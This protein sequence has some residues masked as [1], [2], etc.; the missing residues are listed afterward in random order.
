MINTTDNAFLRCNLFTMQHTEDLIH[1]NDDEIPVM[2]LGGLMSYATI[3]CQV[4]FNWSQLLLFHQALSTINVVTFWRCWFA[5][6]TIQCCK[7]RHSFMTINFGCC[8]AYP[9]SNNYIPSPTAAT[10]VCKCTMVSL[11][12]N[13]PKTTTWLLHIAS[14]SRLV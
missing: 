13:K 6:L 5:E 11:M 12:S 2:I 14:V 1:T 9:H 3:K 8:Y 10:S 7:V 4:S